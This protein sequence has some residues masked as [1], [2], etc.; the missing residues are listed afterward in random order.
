[1]SIVERRDAERLRQQPGPEVRGLPNHYF[2]DPA[3]FALE[4]ER[5]FHRSW[6]FAGVTGELKGPGSVLRKEVAGVPL[7]LTCPREGELKVFQNV[8]PHRGAR[9]VGDDR[10]SGKLMVCPYHSWSFDL[11]GVLRARPH[12]YGIG[13]HGS[14][15]D[16]DREDC[17]GLFEVR[18]AVWNG[19]I[20]INI[21]G[22]APPIEEYLSDLNAQTEHYDIS[23][24]RFSAMIESDFNS[25]W[26]LT[27]ENWL[28]SY[29]VFAVHPG[30]DRMMVGDQRKAAIGAGMLVYADY[31]NTDVGRAVYGSLPIIENLP[32][33][34]KTASFFAAQFPNWA[35]SVHPSYLL[36]WNY[37]P[38]AV[39]KTKVQVFAHF[40][41]DAATSEEHEKA[42]TDLLSYYAGLNEEDMGVCSLMQLG[43]AAP[44]YDG[45]R[46]SPYWDGG[47]VHF[48]RNVERAIQEED[49]A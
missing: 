37:I 20:L 8:C 34:L 16:G 21:D 26:K 9:L 11:D 28:D 5:L 24:M 18:S 38:V 3:H 7:I 4:R 29:H 13:Q 14:P 32:E 49:R 45:G 1:M 46:F 10:D 33:E 42:R 19:A 17:K 22:K 47:S 43:R 44:A 35:V 39:D 41:G 48:A 15:R 12:Y 40:V 30:L 27:I 25:N 23:Q 31:F 6:V 2:T 36:F